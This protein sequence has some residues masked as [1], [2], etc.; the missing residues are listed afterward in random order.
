MWQWNKNIYTFYLDTL[1]VPNQCQVSFGSTNSWSWHRSGPLSLTDMCLFYL[2]RDQVPLPL[3][4]VSLLPWQRP[5][6]PSPD[7]YVPFTLTETRPPLPLTYMCFFPEARSFLLRQMDVLSFLLRY[8]RSFYP[9]KHQVVFTMTNVR[10]FLL[11]QTSDPLYPDSADSRWI[12]GYMTSHP[13][14]SASI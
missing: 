14:C 6:P 12:F 13:W 3:T 2:D 1:S 4:Y 5:G 11:W 10:S 7:I 9:N 8:G